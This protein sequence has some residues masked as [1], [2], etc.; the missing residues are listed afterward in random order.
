[1]Q[2]RRNRRDIAIGNIVDL[3]RYAGPNRGSA[4]PL[5]NALGL[6]LGFTQVFCRPD[7]LRDFPR[8][9]RSISLQNRA[10]RQSGIAQCSAGWMLAALAMGRLV[11]PERL[12]RFYRKE[13]PLAA[14]LSNVNLNGSWAQALHPLPL[15]DY[16]R[17]PPT[18]PMAPVVLN[19]PSL[20]RRHRAGGGN[21]DVVQQRQ[22][23][24]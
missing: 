1:M 9:L 18:G 6:F 24:K 20:G 7:V 13:I 12:Y 17:V 23:V 8:L 16:S 10:H 3:R 11:P 14:G 2:R 5:D 22:R 21:A 19:V 15:L 4:N